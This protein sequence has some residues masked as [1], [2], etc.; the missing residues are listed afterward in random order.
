MPVFHTKTIEG[1]L[2]PVAQQVN[3]LISALSSTFYNVGHISSL[4][5]RTC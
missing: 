5:I 1:I 4:D 3:F 2:E